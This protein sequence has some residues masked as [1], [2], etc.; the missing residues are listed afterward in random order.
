MP[1]RKEPPTPRSAAAASCLSSTASTSTSGLEPLIP[2]KAGQTSLRPQSILT[3]KEYVSGLSS[4][5]KRDFFPDLDRLKAENAYL[6]AVESDDPGR[7][8]KA[9]G[10]LV[11]VD[12]GVGEGKRR[13]VEG[14]LGRGEGGSGHRSEWDDTPLIGA[15]KGAFDPTPAAST[16]GTAY[17]DQV[18]GEAGEE[19]ELVSGITPNL[20][21]SLGAFQAQ[22]TSEGNASFS[23]LLDRDNQRR[24]RKYAH[25]FAREEA[26]NQRRKQITQTEQEDA[27]KGKQLAIEANPGHTKLLEQGRKAMLMFESTTG[28]T[29]G[30]GKEKEKEKI[31]LAERERD[32][33]DDLI[34]VPEPRKDD[35]LALTGLNRWKHTARNA[36][37]FGP[38]AN[39]DILRASLQLKEREEAEKPQTNFSAIRTLDESNPI[40]GWEEREGSE[41]G[42]S[43]SSSRVDAAIQR[44]RGR[45]DSI[46]SSAVD[47][48]DTPKVNGYG[49]IT[50]Y[51]T[52]QHSLQGKGEEKMHLRIYNAIKAKRRTDPSPSLTISGESVSGREFKLP[53]PTRREQLAVK[54][55]ASASLK[56]SSGGLTP[57]GTQKYTGL[58]TLRARAF[59]SPRTKKAGELTPAARALLDRSTRGLTPS[60]GGGVGERGW[61]PTPQRAQRRMP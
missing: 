41:A 35:R 10:R 16:P 55:T 23:Q 61:T 31:V 20:D 9:L 57:Y 39:T 2:L 38:D 18:E 36:L 34:L 6:T 59:S 48:M 8:R 22:Y 24:K 44:G 1:L 47:G 50:P 3:E 58:S 29:L 12:G 51:S 54:L 7:I 17:G 21:L 28:G 42:W 53:N 52:P 14:T 13:R 30:E 32:P 26:S 60:N 4:I 56:P 27:E 46:T 37:M 25:L 19:E 5:I 33:M 15:L 11:R 45:A 40:S 43:P 49:F